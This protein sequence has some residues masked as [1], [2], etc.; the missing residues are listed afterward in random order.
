M[1]VERAHVQ[2]NRTHR[3]RQ[4]SLRWICQSTQRPVEC[5]RHEDSVDVYMQLIGAPEGQAPHSLCSD[6]LKPSSVWRLVLMCAL[7]IR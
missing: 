1:Y 6:A 4:Y 3:D 7:N 2:L 5:S